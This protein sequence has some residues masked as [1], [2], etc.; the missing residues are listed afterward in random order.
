MLLPQII[1][2]LADTSQA[3][4]TLPAM[5]PFHRKLAYEEMTNT[6]K[7]AITTDR[8]SVNGEVCIKVPH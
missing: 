7:N 6:F 3:S 4:M 1:S 5:S 2:F 8:A